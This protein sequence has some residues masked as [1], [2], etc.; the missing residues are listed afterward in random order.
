[1]ARTELNGILNMR[2]TRVQDRNAS[3]ESLE[4]RARNTIQIKSKSTSIVITSNLDGYNVSAMDATFKVRYKLLQSIRDQIL[5]PIVR[6]WL[7]TD[8][9]FVL[10]KNWDF[11]HGIGKSNKG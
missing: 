6:P 5:E 7:T 11:S 10:E 1:M 2:T 4:I 8:A 9:D 3:R